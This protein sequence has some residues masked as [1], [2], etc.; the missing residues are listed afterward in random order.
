VDL[1]VTVNQL[2]AHGARSTL[3]SPWEEAGRFDVNND[4]AL[5]PV[6][7]LHL[8][9]GLNDRADQPSQWWR[10]VDSP[11]QLAADLLDLVHDDLAGRSIDETVTHVD[12]L[13]ELV[14]D[15]VE[16]VQSAVAQHLH[17][18]PP[19]S[20]TETGATRIGE[21]GDLV[22]QH[23]TY[24]GELLDRH[25]ADLPGTEPVTGSPGEGESNAPGDV[26]QWHV[27]YI[28]DLIDSHIHYVRAGV[29]L[30]DIDELIG[31]HVDYLSHLLEIHDVDVNDESL[32]ERA[33]EELSQGFE[34]LQGLGLHASE[35]LGLPAHLADA[36]DSAWRHVAYAGDLIEAHDGV[37]DEDIDWASTIA[38]HVGYVKDLLNLHIRHG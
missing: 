24:L 9:E 34:W 38:T 36:W 8:L 2:N 32:F 28:A 21:A 30:D 4:G 17:G 27:D 23:L 19:G 31:T 11:N 35:R 13:E 29:S 10:E 1:L 22:E 25:I 33:A 12:Y 7:L 16:Y 15:H 37:F 14:L 26:V 5:S 18:D 3:D 6:D 20:N